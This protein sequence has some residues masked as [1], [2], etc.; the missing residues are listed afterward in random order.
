VRSRGVSARRS[1]TGVTATDRR[2]LRY[3]VAIALGG[4]LFGFDAAV[5][6][7]VV[8]FVTP[9][10]DLDD[11][12]IGL[13]V[14]APT[15]GVILAVAQQISGINSVYF[16]APTIFEQSGVGTDAAFAQATYIG[17]TNV[18][19]TILAML[20]V[21]RFDRRPLLMFGLAGVVLSMSVA[22]WGFAQA[23]YELTDAAVATLDEHFDAAGL[24]VLT[25]IRFDSDVQ[26]KRSVAGIVG[27]ATL[28]AHES[29]IIRNA[30]HMNPR[31]VLAG[32]LGFVASFA[33]SL[34]PVYWVLFSEI[35]PN[36]IRGICMSVMGIINSGVSFGVQFLLPWELS[37]LGAAT[38]FFLYGAAALLFLG[39]VARLLPETRGRSLEALEYELCGVP[40][41][42]ASARSSTTL[43]VENR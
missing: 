20:T 25:G 40:S 39:L 18:L 4:F 24:N 13:V 5:I 22:A 12:T 11:W 17:L 9:L 2:A 32:L 14:G 1:T 30:V 7:G 41:A 34:G 42:Q 8:G 19:F 6:S 16:Y 36:A 23:K 29:E 26:F 31:I 43:D 28:R 38:T 15:L 27:E 35:F 37:N 3:A 33:F 21:D 10:F